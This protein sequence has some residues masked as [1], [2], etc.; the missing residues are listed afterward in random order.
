MCEFLLRV[1]E[2]RWAP[3]VEGVVCDGMRPWSLAVAPV[4]AVDGPER[5]ASTEDHAERECGCG[6]EGVGHQRPPP[7]CGMGVVIPSE[8]AAATTALT[9]S[10]DPRGM[11]SILSPLPAGGYLLWEYLTGRLRC[12][13][14]LLIE[15]PCPFP[16]ASGRGGRA[17]GQGRARCSLRSDAQRAEQPHGA[18]RLAAR[19]HAGQ[20][21][22]L[23]YMR[24]QSESRQREGL[25]GEAPSE[26]DCSP[27]QGAPPWEGCQGLR[28]AALPGAGRAVSAWS[29]SCRTGSAIASGSLPG[30]DLQWRVTSASELRFGAAPSW[31]LRWWKSVPGRPTVRL[32]STES[33][34]RVPDK[35][36]VLGDA[37]EHARQLDCCRSPPP[38]HLGSRW[39]YVSNVRWRHRGPGC[40]A[41][42]PGSGGKN[43]GHSRGHAGMVPPQPASWQDGRFAYLGGRCA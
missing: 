41:A 12:W 30:S 21:Q 38:H 25:A 13:R 20:S 26:L 19:R 39:A 33:P 18:H 7:S 2:T 10:R 22:S 35:K 11:L 24:S 36:D 8:G 23:G 37:G 5:V 3:C 6:G 40:A 1:N 42:P 17:A 4:P 29:P 16:P 14:R 32:K 15:V 28:T 34:L 31:N 43:R 27:S 9:A